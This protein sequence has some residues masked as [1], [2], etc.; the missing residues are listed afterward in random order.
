[1]P[2]SECSYMKKRIICFALLSMA[3]VSVAERCK[4]Y[5]QLHQKEYRE[6][7]ALRKTHQRMIMKITNPVANEERLRI[8]RLK[9]Q[10]YRQRIKAAKQDVAT[11]VQEP[12]PSA[13]SQHHIKSRS[14]Q[15]VEKSLPKS[16]RKRSEIVGA[17]VDKF[18]LRIKLTG[19]SKRGRPK[20]E[21]TTDELAWL[22]EF[23]NRPD[24]T[25]TTP[26]RKDQRYVGKIDGKSQFV[27]KRYLLWTLNDLLGIAN[28]VESIQEGCSFQSSFS[29]KLKFHELYEFIKSRR[30]Y[31]YNRDIPQSSC[32]CE[33]CEN[34]VFIAKGVN[35]K[36]LN[37]SLLVPTDPHSLVEAYSCQ[38][39]SKDCMYS[40][41]EDC[42]ITDLS[43]DDFLG[44][45]SLNSDD[46][47]DDVEKKEFNIEYYE[48]TKVDG[49]VKK[50]L[51]SVDI[52]DAIALFND[53]MKVLKAHIFVKRTQ[54]TTYNA[55]KNNL[56][57]NEII[58]HVDYSE[59][60][61]NKEQDEIQ[62]AYFGHSTFSIFTACCYLL[63]VDGNL[64]NENFTI[65]SEAPD[66]SRIAAYSCINR[67]V[68]FLRHKF[69]DQLSS[70]PT[71][72]IWS[73][74]CASQFRSRFVFALISHF[75]R[76]YDVKW[77]YNERHHGKGPMDGIGGT[78]KNMVFQ[79]VKS[80]KCVIEGAKDFAQYADSIIKGI[81]S[82]YMA[83]ADVMQEPSD[84]SEAPKIPGTLKCHKIVRTFNEDNVCKLEF[85]KLASDQEPFYIQWYRKEGD[86]E[87]CGHDQLPLSFNID[88]TCAQ[89]RGQYND[90]QDWLEC[91]LC[92]QWFHETCFHEE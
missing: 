40:L 75:N 70:G 76:A 79:H 30:E 61:N 38:S 15:K 64:I 14:L 43:E 10:E 66:H 36:I 16:P 7:D 46:D 13:F 29:R 1:M 80:K 26:G 72:H 12:G 68:D 31:I 41:C 5:R 8:Q 82:I 83:E 57:E 58:V 11:P 88:T 35:K 90:D 87:V 85:F 20:N 59:N 6:K 28:G 73:D 86:P 32:L 9:K 17:L 69:C 77:Y 84:I 65:T 39:S 54:N 49:K 2:Q 71:L 22:L 25:Y 50:V 62:S 3:P 78:V 51:S 92:D 91:T 23:L 45:G 44:G 24:I 89:C 37:K 52:E 33:I 60:Y 67:I 63:G 81:N 27:Q 55:L 21:F 34:A 48:W 47:G 56:K 19:K 42:N 74:G 53:H 18:Q 4:K